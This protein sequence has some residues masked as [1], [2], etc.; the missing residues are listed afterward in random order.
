MKRAIAAAAVAAGIVTGVAAASGGPTL[1]NPPSLH[2]RAPATYRARFV[3]TK[4]TFFVD[5]TRSWSPRGADRFYN[6]V[7]NHF[8]DRQP[9]FRVI[10]GSL[11]QWGISGTPAI[12]KA[13]QGAYIQDDRLTHPNLR[14][15]LT[16][17]NAGKNTRTTQV[18]VNLADNY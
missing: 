12:A 16:F 18:F 5:V 10:R 9:L 13:W 3:T 2:A 11:V 4:G 15:T 8:Y 17:A 7:L 14:G 6:L 1:L